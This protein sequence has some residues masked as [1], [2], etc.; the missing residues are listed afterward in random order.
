MSKCI[1]V[2]SLS[3]SA[4]VG[5]GFSLYFQESLVLA[6]L[7]MLISVF[8]CLGFLYA[9]CLFRGHGANHSV[10][11]L[12]MPW[13]LGYI[14]LV[15]IAVIAFWA[16]VCS[17][18]MSSAMAYAS[19]TA[20]V[21]G[22]GQW[23]VIGYQETYYASKEEILKALLSNGIDEQKADRI[24]KALERRVEENGRDY[25]GRPQLPE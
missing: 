5:A 19:L 6:S 21:C 8:I 7:N 12:A 25:F 4:F 9:N 10:H 24:I 23:F 1:T 11:F 18:P 3:L 2:L 17:H 15:S 14:Y 16:A 22:I 13:K 20:W